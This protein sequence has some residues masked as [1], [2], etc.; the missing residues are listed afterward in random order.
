MILSILYDV[1]QITG[2]LKTLFSFTMGTCRTAGPGIF[3][4]EDGKISI[5]YS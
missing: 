5:G 3:D 1:T 4:K 2:M